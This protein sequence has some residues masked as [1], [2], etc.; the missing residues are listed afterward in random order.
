M[1]GLHSQRVADLIPI[2]DNYKCGLQIF[3]LILDVYCVS[4]I[5]VKALSLNLVH[6][7]LKHIQ[8]S[9]LAG[10]ANKQ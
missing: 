5:F 4:C 9:E 7:N 6:K 3:V 1:V 8:H 10:E 2:Q